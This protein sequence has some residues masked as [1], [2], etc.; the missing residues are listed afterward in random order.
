[1]CSFSIAAIIND[2]KCSDLKQQLFI[3]SQFYRSKVQVQVGL[4][5][6]SAMGFTT[7]KLRY[8]W[9]CCPFSRPWRCIRFQ[10]QSHC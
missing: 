10:A 5:W 8:L 6:F 9:G 2:H 3:V 7:L 1:M 4:S